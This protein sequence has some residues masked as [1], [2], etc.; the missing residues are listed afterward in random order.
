MTGGVVT[1]DDVRRLVAGLPRSYEAHV[2]GRVKFRAGRI[3]SLAFS[4]DERIMGPAFHKEERE[5]VKG[6]L[7][8]RQGFHLPHA[9]SPS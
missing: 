4:K 7:D 3:V 2:R 9:A 8:L 1:I 5:A 6:R